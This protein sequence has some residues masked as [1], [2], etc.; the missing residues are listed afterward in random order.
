M[1]YSKRTDSHWARDIF[2]SSHFPFR[3]FTF[4]LHNSSNIMLFQI[5][6]R[7][8]IQVYP[9]LIIS[10]FMFSP[11]FSGL[12]NCHCGTFL[13]VVATQA[14]DA[15]FQPNLQIC[16]KNLDAKD[17]HW[18]QDFVA[19]GFLLPNWRWYQVKARVVE[20][21]KLLTQGHEKPCQVQ[22]IEVPVKFNKSRYLPIAKTPP[23]LAEYPYPNTSLIVS[24]P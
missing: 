7:F 23:D 15:R 22:Q 11:C 1:S 12:R 5:F 8:L 19:H 21:S 10:L 2:S 17:L 9:L 20:W 3:F 16:I 14:P 13:K 6:P 18:E 4:L 24:G